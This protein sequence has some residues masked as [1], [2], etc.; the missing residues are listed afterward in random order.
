MLYGNSRIGEVGATGIG[1]GWGDP[2]D[3]EGV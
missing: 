1:L 3:T 2:D